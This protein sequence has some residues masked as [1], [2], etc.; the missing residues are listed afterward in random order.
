MTFSYDSQENEIVIDDE[1]DDKAI[2]QLVAGIERRN[3]GPVRA[4]SPIARN[5]E[6]DDDRAIALFSANFSRPQT[7]SRDGPKRLSGGCIFDPP[8]KSRKRPSQNASDDYYDS[9]GECFADEQSTVEAEDD[10]GVSG[11]RPRKRLSHS[12]VASSQQSIGPLDPDKPNTRGARRRPA[13]RIESCEMEAIAA[14]ANR[15]K[16]LMK[17]RYECRRTARRSMSHNAGLSMMTSS[18]IISSSMPEEGEPEEGMDLMRLSRSRFERRVLSLPDPNAIIR[19]SQASINEDVDFSNE[20]N[21]Q[22]ALSASLVAGSRRLSMMPSIGDHVEGWNFDE[23]IAVHSTHPQ[24]SAIDRYGYVGTKSTLPPSISCHREESSLPNRP[25]MYHNTHTPHFN[26]FQSGRSGASRCARD[27]SSSFTEATAI[28]FMDLHKVERSR[29][30]TD[31]LFLTPQLHYG[32]FGRD[33]RN[34]Y[35]VQPQ[36]GVTYNGSNGVNR[37]LAEATVAGSKPVHSLTQKTR[38]GMQTK[39]GGLED[40]Y[41]DQCQP[42]HLDD[43]VS[44]SLESSFNDSFDGKDTGFFASKPTTTQEEHV[45]K[46]IHNAIESDDPCIKN[47]VQNYREST[48]LVLNYSRDECTDDVALHLAVRYGRF[49]AMDAILNADKN[50]S[51][52][53]NSMGQVP[54]HIAI[55]RGNFAAVAS[56]CAKCPASAQVQCEEGCLPLHDAVSTPARHQDSPQITATL[57]STFPKAVLVT[58]DEGLLPIH[59]AAMSGFATGLRTIFGYNF[60]TIYSREST[61]MM[62]P[63]DFAV[64][65]LKGDAEDSEL[66][67]IA[68]QQPLSAQQESDLKSNFELCTEVLL[69]STLHNRPILKPR[70]VADKSCLFLPLHGAVV[71]YPILQRT[72]KNIIARYGKNHINDVDEYGCN[73]AHL[74]CSKVMED[75]EHNVSMLQDIH[76][77]E[78]TLF[79]KTDQSGLLPLHQFLLKRKSPTFDSVKAV[80]QFNLNALITEV[81]GKSNYHGFLPFQ[82]AAVSGCDENV[83]LY[84]LKQHPEGVVSRLW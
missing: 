49:N 4:A 82:V 34:L 47:L 10:S 43:G 48:R 19:L 67:S 83:I 14:T 21:G 29:S 69:I 51:L 25:G 54:L 66:L 18:S 32:N 41:I 78:P 77:I 20:Y 46:I 26:Q 36:A 57:L 9:D 59:Y 12:S 38:L 5:E 72:W 39:P 80:V 22:T 17:D 37:P 58:T 64:D 23:D 63:L 50:S 44:T 28:D 84:L 70:D 11:R 3:R 56:I 35:P 16:L 81:R 60:E 75:V 15:Q 40:M 1:A 42:H 30:Q 2:A 13:F 8:I 31:N 24:L 73:V 52:I 71:A 76:K 6:L 55:E 74:L 33:Q 79:S 53:R 27:F 61:E 65:G 62:L 68:H 7:Q 45:S